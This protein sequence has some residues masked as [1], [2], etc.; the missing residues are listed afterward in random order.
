MAKLGTTTKKKSVHASTHA[1]T[2]AHKHIPGR[3]FEIKNPAD[4]LI[5][6]IGGGFFNE[7]HYYDSKRSYA[8]F[9]AEWIAQGGKIT[10]RILDEVGLTEQ[11]KDV[12]QAM[13]DVAESDNP[14]DLLI[15]AAW[16]RD[17]KHGLKIRTTPNIALALAAANDRTKPFVRKYATSIMLRADE[18]R[19]VFAA[20]RHLFC[21]QAG[22]LHKGMLPH[23]LRK[24]LA[25]AYASYS[26][27]ELL[28][29][30]SP[31]SP[32]HKDVLLMIQGMKK[33]PRRYRKS[34]QGLETRQEDGYPL[35]KA[36]FDYIVNG[37][38]SDDLPEIVT[39]REH[40]F[41]K[42]KDVKEVTPE[43]LEKAG[44]TW[45]NVLS[46]FGSKKEVWEAV[47]P[48][49]DEMAITRN[50]RN[51]EEAKVS[52]AAWDQIYKKCENLK[53]SVQLPFRFFAA[54]RE[55]SSTDAKTAVSIQC[56]NAVKSL[57]DL[58]GVT[59]LLVDNSGSAVGAPISGKSDLRI[60]DTGNM[61]AAVAAKRFGRRAIIGVFGDSLVWVPFNGTDSTISIKKM[62]D[63]KAQEE[64]RSKNGALGFDGFKHGRGVGGGTETG[65][66][67]AIQDLMDRKIHVDRFVLLSDLCCYTQND[68]NCGHPM[69]KVFGR[70]GEK[71][72]VESMFRRYRRTVNKDCHVYS[73]N[74]A[75][76]AQSQIDSNEKNHLMS[77]WSEQIFAL[78]TD[79]E[80]RSAQA[81]QAKTE[82]AKDLPTIQALRDRY[83]KN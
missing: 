81:K 67:W 39:T 69:T 76:Y 38:I 54:E 14:E 17:K 63:A 44:L 55:T 49:M 79:I 18:P 3:A 43:L 6:I 53:E 72:T 42:I 9:C 4:K 62:I 8:A 71:A 77:G 19:Q 7:P 29:W 5:H 15:I 56:D 51:F 45:E 37:K 74:L 41:K 10:S 27:Y 26:P 36:M 75:G 25:E 65:L 21:K 58:P 47:I 80:G 60:S 73:V 23:C 70:D 12:V 1:E 68:V 16:A 50:L 64:E 30:N 31:E 20:F 48:M 28:K 57:P 11:A 52:K 13:K 32:T 82:E 61:L 2:V 24:A 66:W 83:R 22:G 34:K 78:M 46:H 59:V 40:F 35:S 33:L